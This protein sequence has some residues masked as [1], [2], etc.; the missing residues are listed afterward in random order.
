MLGNRAMTE[1]ALNSKFLVTPETVRKKKKLA[2][3]PVP[4]FRKLLVVQIH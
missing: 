1:K 3:K 2:E 4:A